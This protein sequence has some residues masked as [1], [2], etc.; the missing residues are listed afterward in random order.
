MF[1][2]A[3]DQ[4]ETR[5]PIRTMAIQQIDGKAQLIG[6]YTCSPMVMVPLEELVNG[7]KISAN[8]IADIGNGQPLDMI[9]FSLNG[10]DLLFL[11]NDSRSPQVIPVGGLHNAQVVTHESF[12]RGPKL[13]LHP[14]MPYGPVGKTVMFDGVSLHMDLL[15]DGLFVSLT[16]DVYTGNL[17][18]DSNPTFFPNS[19]HNMYAEFDFPQY[20]AERSN[21]NR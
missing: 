12:E 11:T 2:I 20:H 7:A 9:P 21:E 14:L 16:R 19:I 3:H 17:N 13:D 18:L 15:S 4:Y 1:H 10:Q 8:T 6:A 5:A